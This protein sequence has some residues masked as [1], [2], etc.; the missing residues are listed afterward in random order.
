MQKLIYKGHPSRKEFQTEGLS[1]V[2][3]GGKKGSV[4][5]RIASH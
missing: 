5:C 1:Y 3:E 4:V 2:N